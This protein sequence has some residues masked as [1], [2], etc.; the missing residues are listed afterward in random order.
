MMA[1]ADSKAT[2]LVVDD[3]EANRRLARDTLEDEEYRVVLAQ[4]GREALDL[5]VSERPDCV[6]LDA[7]MPEMD[8]FAVCAR[9]RALPE[10]ADTPIVFLTAHRDIDTF[11]RALAAG[12]DD[13]VSKPVRPTELVVRVR[14]ALKMRRMKT[15]LD[16]QFVA[17]RRQRDDL[18]RLQLQ[19]E[20]L[21][22]Y[23]VHDLKN[24]VN[25]MDLHAQALLGERL[26]EEAN[27]SLRA[28]RSG[29]RQ[30]NRM[31]GNLLDL[32]KGDEG[33]LVAERAQVSISVLVKEVF[34]GL[35]PAAELHDVDLVSDL[36]VGESYVD[37]NLFRRLLANLVDNAIQHAPRGTPVRV[38]G[39]RS[40]DGLLLDV[41]DAGKG[42]AR[43]TRATIFDPFVQVSGSKQEVGRSGHGLGLTFCKLVADAHGGHISIEDTPRGAHFRVWIPD[44]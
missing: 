12:A 31:I 23:V 10:N 27:V 40:G 19:K 20:R 11:D 3:N 15:E 14:A 4:G 34:D 25:A 32:S 1:S 7:A 44:V 29:A 36:R 28:I 6:L 24:P 2:I 9:I 33:R 26:P 38:V 16:E 5:F 13:F 37:A 41:I 43:E 8:G 21:I 18:L 35:A 22:A 42:I 17:M 39:G 30:L